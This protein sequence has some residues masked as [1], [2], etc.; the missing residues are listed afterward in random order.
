MEITTI[1]LHTGYRIGV[2]D[3]RIFGGFLEHLGRAV[4]E[5]VYDPRSTRPIGW[6]PERRAGCPAS[7]QDDGDALSGW[8]LCLRLPLDDGVGPREKHPTI[9]E[10]AWQSLE[11]NCSAPT[12]ISSYA[13]KMELDSDD[14][15]ESG[16]GDT[17][18]ARN[19]VEY[20]NCPPGSKY[21]DMRAA[22]GYL[23]PYGVK[24]WCLGNEMD[25]PGNW[26]M[27]R[28]RNTPS[29]LSRRPR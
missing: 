16:N 22:N 1:S 8:Q 10:L 6:F 2:V 26:G 7:A 21:A 14:H 23:E 3:S 28:L 15:G 13:G 18:E 9:R 27:S 19:W 17:E 4:Y 11:P 29:V 24:L 20:C 12:S 25:G 5:G